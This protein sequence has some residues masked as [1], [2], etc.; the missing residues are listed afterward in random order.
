MEN[1]TRRLP[2][3]NARRCAFTG[4]RPIKMPFGYDEQCEMAQNFKK[5]LYST[6]ETL[7]QQGYRH[8]IS[9][10]AQG[11]DIMAAEAVLKLKKMYPDIT[12]EMAIPF[13]AQAAKWSEDYQTRWQRCVDS[14]DMITVISHEYTRNCLFAR[15][16]YLVEQADLL[17][18]CF[19]GKEG[20]TKMTVEYAKRY[21]CRVCLMP[22]AK[23]AKTA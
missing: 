2:A 16:R 1:I 14:A 11:M 19:D 12:L 7:I 4:H 13:E 17:L 9:G 15:N 23:N 6:I 5:R 22:P 10:G 21:G 20:G 3:T 8:M 18:A